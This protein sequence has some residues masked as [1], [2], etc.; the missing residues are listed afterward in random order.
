MTRPI[1]R[2]AVQDVQTVQQGHGA[3]RGQQQ[4]QY[5]GRSRLRGGV[6]TDQSDHAATQQQRQC[7]RRDVIPVEAGIPVAAVVAVHRKSP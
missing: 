3:E 5:D 6:L 7:H 1:P 4:T 2:A